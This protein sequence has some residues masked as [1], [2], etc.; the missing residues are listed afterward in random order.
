M[1]SEITI[2][3]IGVGEPSDVDN[4]DLSQG[5]LGWEINGNGT[6]VITPE[7]N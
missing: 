5:L 7:E 1:D 2:T 4:N 6:V 3:V